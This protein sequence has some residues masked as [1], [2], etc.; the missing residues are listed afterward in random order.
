MAFVL[1]SS[2]PYGIR[3]LDDQSFRHNVCPLLQVINYRSSIFAITMPYPMK[4]I[5]ISSDL[6]CLLNSIAVPIPIPK[7]LTQD[8]INVPIKERRSSHHLRHSSVL[9][10]A[11]QL[12]PLL[13]LPPAEQWSI[14]DDRRIDARGSHVLAA[15]DRLQVVE[16]LLDGGATATSLLVGVVG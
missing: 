9:L 1:V 4:Q 15:V 10:V 11:A 14:L 5:T 6:R 7:A 12:V 2:K 8:S 3:L 13:I 16:D